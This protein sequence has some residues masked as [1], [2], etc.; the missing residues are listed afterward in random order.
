MSALS[1]KFY[2]DAG[3]ATELAQLSLYGRE[4]KFVDNNRVI[5]LGSPDAG[6]YWVS[7]HNNP[8]IRLMAEFDYAR[9]YQDYQ[10]AYPPPMAVSSI[11]LCLASDYVM[12]D[13][14]VFNHE[15]QLPGEILGGI[16]NAIAINVALECWDAGTLDY[17]R[18]YTDL[19][20]EL[21]I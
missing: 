12:N 4:G 20:E 16:G 11:R 14:G 7:A 19:L 10:G 13:P 1:I 2:E 8:E 21:D 18:L 6:K 17:F 3:L 15:I 5:Y 9:W